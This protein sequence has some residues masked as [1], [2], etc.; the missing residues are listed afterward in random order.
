MAGSGE[1]GGGGG[2]QGRL[3]YAG[4]L[5]PLKSVLL[6]VQFNSVLT[7]FSLCISEQI[8]FQNQIILFCVS[9]YICLVIL[10]LQNKP[11]VKISVDSFAFLV[12]LAT[13]GLCL[14]FPISL[15]L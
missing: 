8:I 11:L 10:L 15:P 14:S 13:Q 9:L 3:D 7:M 12:A 4:I 1:A 6:F 5:T 2:R